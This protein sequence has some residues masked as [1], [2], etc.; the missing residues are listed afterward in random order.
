MIHTLLAGF[1]VSQGQLT[2]AIKDSVYNLS[3]IS[4]T[5]LISLATT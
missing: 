4:K 5:G 3:T 1:L 2:E